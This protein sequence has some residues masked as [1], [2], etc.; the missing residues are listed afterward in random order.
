MPSNEDVIFS[1]RMGGEVRRYHTWPT[2]RQQTVADH[3][4][5]VLRIYWHLFGEVPPEVTAYLLHHDVCE[6]RVGDPPHPIKLHNPELKVVYDRLEDETLVEMLGEERAMNVLGSVNDLERVR[7]KACDLL[8]MAEF[9]GV[10]VN[11]GNKY[12]WPIFDNV[13][14]AIA[15]LLLTTEDAFLVVNHYNIQARSASND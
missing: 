12:A 4:F 13:A 7:M 5:H 8:E 11:L 6:V 15:G 3:T 14:R 1:P 9:A 10:E 2:I